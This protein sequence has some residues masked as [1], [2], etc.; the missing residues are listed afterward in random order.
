MNA[1]SAPAPVHQLTYVDYIH[2]YFAPSD[3]NMA[4]AICMAES[5][6]TSKR[7]NT[8]NYNGTYDWGI[9]QVNDIHKAK[10]GGNVLLFLDPA[11]NVKVAAQIK[12]GSGWSAWSTFNNGS[13]RQYLQ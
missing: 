7:S 4:Q 11:T 13:Y 2:Q 10:V 6:C 9:F 12:A 3:W 8:M 5:H 1:I